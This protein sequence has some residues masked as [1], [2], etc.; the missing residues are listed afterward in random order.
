MQRPRRVDEPRVPVQETETVWELE[1]VGP[2]G[3]GG[4]A[5]GRE[6]WVVSAWVPT[7]GARAVWDEGEEVGEDCAAGW[8][9]CRRK[10]GRERGWK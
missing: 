6:G 2:E 3:E 10:I 9:C 4:G 7:W 5:E 1:E 8:G